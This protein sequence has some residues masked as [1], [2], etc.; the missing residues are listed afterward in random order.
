MKPSFIEQTLSYYWKPFLTSF[1]NIP[2]GES[3][4]SALWICIFLTKSLVLACAVRISVY[5]IPYLF[6][7]YSFFLLAETIISSK[8]RLHQPKKRMS[9]KNTF[10][11]NGKRNW[12]GSANYEEKIVF[13]CREISCPL[14]IM[15]SFSQNYSLLIPIMVSTSTEIALAKKILFLLGRKF[16]FTSQVKDIEKY[17]STIWKSCFHFKKSLKILKK[18]VST[19]RNMIRF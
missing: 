1:L 8:I 16:I 9:L 13:T 6:F 4:F 18:L 2:T 17:V 10:A 15:S 11:L 7:I 5:R 14:A 19:S 12:Q 3:S